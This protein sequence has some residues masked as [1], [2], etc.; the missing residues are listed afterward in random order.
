MFLMMQY[1]DEYFP[2][3]KNDW[4]C[5]PPKN[6]KTVCHFINLDFNQQYNY[7]YMLMA[8]KNLDQ[9]LTKPKKSP[10]K[11]QRT[12]CKQIQSWLKFKIFE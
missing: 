9:P 1:A 5:C 6:F 11:I 2:E 7:L 4:K 12:N 10:N 3:L 8:R